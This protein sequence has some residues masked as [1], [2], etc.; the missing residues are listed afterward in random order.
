MW[1]RFFFPSLSFPPAPSPPLSHRATHTAPMPRVRPL[2]RVQAQQQDIVTN[3]LHNRVR[4]NEQQRHLL[5]YMDGTR[6]Y[7]ALEAILAEL[8]PLPDDS[9]QEQMAIM[10]LDDQLRWLEHH[11]LLME[12]VNL[13]H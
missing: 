2:A 1:D 5:A 9:S 10:T 13:P 4:L 7:A 11:A 3:L 8:S 12:P 6:D